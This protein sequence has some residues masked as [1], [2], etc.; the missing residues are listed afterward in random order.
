MGE[1]LYVSYVNMLT[2]YTSMKERR[3]GRLKGSVI[4]NYLL[5]FSKK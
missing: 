4:R 5:S 3:E 2:L 1:D